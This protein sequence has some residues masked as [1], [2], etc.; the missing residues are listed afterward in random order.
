MFAYIKGTLISS[1]PSTAILD[2]H[3]IGYQILIPANVFAKLPQ[4]NNTIT[5]HTSYIVRELSHTLYGFLDHTDCELF[6][7]LMSVTGIGPK[8]A[9][10]VIGHLPTHDLQQAINNHNLSAICR[11]PGIGKKTAE[12]LIIEL[13]DKIQ[14]VSPT[15]PSTPLNPHSQIINDAM[16]AL[17]NLGY[18]QQVA[19]KAIK[20][21]LQSTPEPLNLALLITSSLKNI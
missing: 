5:L 16:N 11:V 8:I 2:V 12:R 9:L 20:T 10:S 17:I 15:Q 18:N 21:T 6:E 4:P 13:R 19:Q 7:L 14:H 3:G 1:T